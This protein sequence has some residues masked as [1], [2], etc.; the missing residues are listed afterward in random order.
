M[1]IFIAEPT[2]ASS[3]WF[4]IVAASVLRTEQLAVVPEIEGFLAVFWLSLFRERIAHLNIEETE[5][6]F[7]YFFEFMIELSIR[8]E[9]SCIVEHRG[10]IIGTQSSG[11]L[12][13]LVVNH[14]GGALACG[15]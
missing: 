12:L 2:V 1:A 8:E 5:L 6:H 7:L 15:N 10:R 13:W 4:T 3:I 14:Y 11:Y 9:I